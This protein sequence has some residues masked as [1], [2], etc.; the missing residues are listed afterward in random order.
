MSR[1][2]S[3]QGLW[4][5]DFDGTIKPEGDGRVAPADLDALKRLGDLGWFRVVA[6]GRSLF[7]FVKAWE[8]GLEL[9]A[10]IFSSGVGRCAW[11]PMGPGP[12]LAARVF[13]PEVA[14]AALQAA[15]E[16]GYGFFA[17]QAPPDNHHFYYQRSA[18]VPA[19]FERRLE[20]YAAQA[21]PWSGD[22]F[23][24]EPAEPLS[25]VHI[26]VPAPELGRV[27]AEFRRLM[28]ER[29]RRPEEELSL[30]HSSSPFGD[31]CLWL[32]IFPPKI[33]KGRAAAELAR[34]LGLAPDRAV[35]LGNDYNDRDLLNWAGRSFVTADAP[36]EL[37]QRH[38]AM[39]PA[40]RGGLAWAL[41]TVLG[42][43]AGG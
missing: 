35:A 33:T 10:L 3:I 14:A 36:E 2:G 30:V 4:L 22:F 42:P 41:E 37:R 15:L 40:G 12:L 11:G 18:R 16:L 38:P 39:P 19:G 24:R 25:Q 7:G 23:R 17:Y 31:G 9:D 13:A 6:T 27:E 21:R 1:T 28:R 20:I 26:M 43:K 32:E 8:P 5:T 34:D 29:G